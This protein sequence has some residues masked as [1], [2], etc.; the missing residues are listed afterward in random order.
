[1]TAANSLLITPTMAQA[2]EVPM[3]PDL[4]SSA[5]ELVRKEFGGVSASTAAVDELAMVDQVWLGLWQYRYTV[6][7]TGVAVDVQW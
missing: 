4:P 6:Q 5:R 2:T 7:E 1:M 3:L